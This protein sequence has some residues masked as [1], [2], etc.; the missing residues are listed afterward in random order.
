MWKTQVGSNFLLPPIYTDFQPFSSSLR[1]SFRDDAW[2]SHF[3]LYLDFFFPSLWLAR[4]KIWKIIPPK[5]IQY[6]LILS[7]RFQINR[8]IDFLWKKEQEKFEELPDDRL[9]FEIN[10]RR[11][12]SCAERE[13]CSRFEVTRW[14]EQSG[15]GG[16]G[17]VFGQILAVEK[18]F[19][20]P[21]DAQ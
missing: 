15:A 17:R 11:M 4:I 6:P 18:F 9:N 19:G 3:R 1:Y 13:G 21:G 8:T 5:N 20:W 12:E 10:G 14:A 7:P 16:E 2:T